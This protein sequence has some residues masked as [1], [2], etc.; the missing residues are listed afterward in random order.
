QSSTPR[1]LHIHASAYASSLITPA[2]FHTSARRASIPTS[3]YTHPT[4]PH[5]SK[6]RWLDLSI[7][8]PHVDMHLDTS[9][10][11]SLQAFMPR[12]STYLDSSTPSH[13]PHLDTLIHTGQLTRHHT[14]KP[15]YL[16]TILL[17]VG[18]HLHANIHTH[19]LSSHLHTSMLNLLTLIPRYS[20]FTSRC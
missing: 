20:T 13:L 17:C 18:M 9:I 16:N 5:V 12:I 8:C 14:C 4:F 6:P 3:A 1:Y 11:A 15:P 10:L 2:Q 7:P 19:N